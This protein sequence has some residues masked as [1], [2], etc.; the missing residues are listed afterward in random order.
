MEDLPTEDQPLY[1]IQRGRRPTAREFV[2]RN[3]LFRDLGSL[4]SSYR[5]KHKKHLPAA[6]LSL[7]PHGTELHV[8]FHD[9]AVSFEKLYAADLLHGGY[10]DNRMAERASSPYETGDVGAPSN[11]GKRRVSSVFHICNDDAQLAHGVNSD[12]QNQR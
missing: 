5:S 4:F 3:V 9:V 2:Y 11:A 12:V 10:R 6:S 7:C 8:Y 1:A